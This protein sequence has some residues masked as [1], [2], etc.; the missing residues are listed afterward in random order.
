M[1][2]KVLSD[3]EIQALIEYLELLIEISKDNK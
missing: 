2:A 3:E 1:S